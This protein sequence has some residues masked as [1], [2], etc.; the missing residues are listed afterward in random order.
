MIA[1]DGR[2]D[3]MQNSQRNPCRIILK[4]SG[5]E[6]DGFQY[7]GYDV[8]TMIVN[9]LEKDSVEAFA[10]KAASLGPV[11]YFIDTAGAS[12]NQAKP[13]HI[14]ASHPSS[15]NPLFPFLK[16]GIHWRSGI[17]PRRH[18]SSGR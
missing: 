7:S 16:G 15:Q 10:R 14:I 5:N 12:P 3:K 9:A 6:T 17:R 18:D 13:E 8:E 4:S 1:N 2:F 11:R